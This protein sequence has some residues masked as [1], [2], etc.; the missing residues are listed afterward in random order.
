MTFSTAF[1]EGFK[2]ISVFGPSFPFLPCPFIFFFLS[3][4]RLLVRQVTVFVVVCVVLF[5]K[6]KKMSGLLSQIQAGVE[7]FHPVACGVLYAYRDGSITLPPGTSVEHWESECSGLCHTTGH[8]G[9]VI[10]AIV[11]SFGYIFIFLILALVFGS[12]GLHSELAFKKATKQ[13]LEGK[14][15]SA[16]A[17]DDS[18]AAVE[19]IPSRVAGVSLSCFNL[20]YR[21]PS[22]K[23]LIKGV[24]ATFRPGML[25]A[26]M[27]PS[28]SGKTTTL[29][30]MAGR[31]ASGTVRGHRSINGKVYV[32][33]QD[34]RRAVRALSGYVLQRDRFQERFTVLETLMYASRLRLPDSVSPQAAAARVQEVLS[35]VDLLKAQDA[36]V[37]GTTFAGISGGQMRRLS[38]ALELLRDPDVLFLD[39][40][41]SGLDATSSLSI[42]QLCRDLCDGAQKTILVTIHQ[43]RA[44]IVDLFNEVCLLVEGH[45]SFLGPFSEALQVFGSHREDRHDEIASKDNAGDFLIDLA[46]LDVMEMRKPENL[47]NVQG[48]MIEIYQSTLRYQGLESSLSQIFLPPGG[49][50]SS[51]GRSLLSAFSRESKPNNN[52]NN[53]TKM[54]RLATQMQGMLLRTLRDQLGHWRWLVVIANVVVVAVVLMSAFLPAIS[55]EMNKYGALFVFAPWANL[56]YAATFLTFCF[57]FAINLFYLNSIPGFYADVGIFYREYNGGVVLMPA[58]LLSRNLVNTAFA[59][60]ITP[61][62]ILM[63]Y[64]F[65]WFKPTIVLPDS[66]FALMLFCATFVC[67]YAFAAVLGMFMVLTQNIDRA[68]SVALV[69]VTL[70]GLFSGLVVPYTSFRFWLWVYYTNPVSYILRS[71]F[72]SYAENYPGYNTCGG[73]IRAFTNTMPSQ[74]PMSPG[75]V[76]K[77]CEGFLRASN[78]PTDTFEDASNVPISVGRLLLMQT[79]LDNYCSWYNVLIAVIIAILGNIAVFVMMATKLSFQFRLKQD[80]GGSTQQK[81]SANTKDSEESAPLHLS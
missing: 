81:E 49:V 20:E 69:I 44:E 36:R 41:T 57:V 70:G 3:F 47:G 63:V 32:R 66:H 68:Y 80:D 76:S 35:Q 17:K 45:L 67:V 52:N 75:D 72:L 59:T 34:Y 31:T 77:I 25:Y 53:E 74:E 24:T 39:E 55:P 37:G 50:D 78:I 60:L 65:F 26:V 13:L 54:P 11:I 29:D 5:S 71:I 73:I 61:T 40:P 56:F 62:L 1:R 79:P 7:T 21:I 8:D 30:L 64:I 16:A 15:D 19:V 51:A 38:V 43:P 9:F 22:G 18:A 33:P 6:E 27:G 4:V 12:L 23:Q 42:I 2:R 14:D 28:G 48:T 58:F 10:P 46:G